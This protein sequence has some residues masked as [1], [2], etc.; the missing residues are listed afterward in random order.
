[1]Q[2]Q[3]GNNKI[4]Q[5]REQMNQLFLANPELIDSIKFTKFGDSAD[6][7]ET[8]QKARISSQPTGKARES[9]KLSGFVTS[10]ESPSESEDL[11]RDKRAPNSK[12]WEII[13]REMTRISKHSKLPTIKRISNVLNIYKAKLEKLEQNYDLQAGRNTS[14]G[15]NPSRSLDNL[16]LADKKAKSSE[17]NRS[18]IKDAT[19][20]EGHNAFV[21]YAGEEGVTYYSFKKQMHLTMR[22]K[23]KLLIDEGKKEQGAITLQDHTI[24]DF[25]ETGSKRAFGGN[26]STVSEGVKFEAAGSINYKG[27]PQHNRRKGSS[28]NDSKSA[29]TYKKQKPARSS[30]MGVIE[31][32]TKDIGGASKKETEEDLLNGKEFGFQRAKE[33]FIEK[34][35]YGDTDVFKRE[36]LKKIKSFK[37]DFHDRVG[38]NLVNGGNTIK[39]QKEKKTKRLNLFT[40]EFDRGLGVSENDKE[41]I[42]SSHDSKKFLEDRKVTSELEALNKISKMLEG[43]ITLFWK[44][45]LEAAS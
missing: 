11:K 41:I 14:T 38:A 5:L 32:L 28:I 17:L 25:E 26:K 16:V 3:P 21:E 43:N 9:K 15:I 6:L 22:E 36:A 37:S 7:K 13:S 40:P 44:D 8:D 33:L 35:R 45:S 24:S 4:N 18:K 20:E 39:F 23:R 10:D 19:S 1:M 27:F 29:I 2:D 31:R 42:F 34:K 30:G 12:F